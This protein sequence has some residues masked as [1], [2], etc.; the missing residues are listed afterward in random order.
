MALLR[1]RDNVP[2]SRRFQMREKLASIGD[3]SWIE[4]DQGERVYKVDGKAMR[5]RE[6]FLLRDRDG[7]EVAKNLLRQLKP[8]NLLTKPIIS[9]PDAQALLSGLWLWH[10]W[11]DESHTI[12]Q[13]IETETGSFWHASLQLA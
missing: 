12:S 6:T 3:D 2:D 4:D 13:S 7:N 8:D 1:H 9:Q 11:L 5:V 10:D